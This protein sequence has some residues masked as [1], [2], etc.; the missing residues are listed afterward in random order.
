MSIMNMFFSLANNN[1]VG[2]SSRCSC[3][4]MHKAVEYRP[5]RFDMMHALLEANISIPVAKAQA[6]KA[7]FSFEAGIQC[8][9]LYR[10]PGHP[11]KTHPQ[12]S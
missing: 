3:T 5:F 2:S 4:Y 11:R 7:H 9:I 1:Q 6:T 8:F 10:H 12:S